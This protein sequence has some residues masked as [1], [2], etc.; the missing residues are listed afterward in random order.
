MYKLIRL[1]DEK[2]RKNNCV[3][4]TLFVGRKQDFLW[5]NFN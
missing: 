1:G 3:S 2:I 5:K 4:I